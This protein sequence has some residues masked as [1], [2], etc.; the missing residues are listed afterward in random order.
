MTNIKN[1]F[2][3]GILQ[4]MVTAMPVLGGNSIA[5]AAPAES[6]PKP[7]TTQTVSTTNKLDYAQIEIKDKTSLIKLFNKSLTLLP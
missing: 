3:R 1:S 7:K 2:K 6:D 5:A 4:L